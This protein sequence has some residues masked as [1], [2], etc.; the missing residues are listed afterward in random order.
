MKLFKF[1]GGVHPEEH[2]R[3][4]SVK[5]I[6]VM[7]IPSHLYVPL[8]QHIGAP[9]EPSVKVGDV[10]LKGQLLA[11]SQGAISAPIHAPTSGTIVEI[12]EY[13]A[14]HPSGLPVR[15]IVLA[16]DG[17]DKWL[18][19]PIND[20][21]PLQASSAEIALRVGAA[22]IVGMGGA[23]FPSAVKL[24]LGSKHKIHTLV[25][26]GGECEPYLTCD[27][28]LMQEHADGIVDGA[29]IILHTIGAEKALLVV[30]DNK[31]AAI[32]ALQKACGFMGNMQ[33]VQVPAQYPMGSEKHM[34]K[35]VTG[36]EVPAGGLGADIG[37]LVHN[38][39]TAYAVHQ[40]IRHNRPLISRVITVGGGA[41]KEPQNVEVPI[42]ALLSDVIAFC[43]GLVEAPARI[44]MGGP[45]MGQMMPSL[46]IPVVKGSS[47]I[48]ALTAEE[49]AANTT[50]PC[51]RC[52]SCVSACPCGLLPLQMAAHAK[53][54]NLEQVVDFGL[55]DCVSCGCCSYVCPSHIPLVQYFNYAKGEIAARQQAKHKAQ[56]NR[57]L[58]EQRNQRL[59]RE[60]QAKAEAAAKRKAAKAAK[61]I[62]AE[63]S[64]D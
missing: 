30:E 46:N 38:M 19:S 20:A 43:G 29:R 21:D 61:S 6:R 7:P 14:P 52:G 55:V 34:I 22:G 8:Q 58:V 45:M 59:E 9:A 54:G 11:H 28:R 12:G 53:A 44:L 26:N 36:L 40:A 23:T 2:K 64:L 39:G 15:T 50:M 10:V 56:E 18:E 42:G 35:A 60:V 31:P 49:V 62:N 41:V 27:D 33:V 1:H 57:R 32:V 4:T 47:G 48:I 13:P 24:R 17:E 63:L 51:I 3:V 16:A 37:V 5:P 25:L